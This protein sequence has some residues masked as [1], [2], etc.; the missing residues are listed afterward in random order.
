MG[1]EKRPYGSWPSPITTDLITADV[2]TL[3]EVRVDGDDLYWI[4]MRPAEK[5]RTVIVR[6]SAEGEI[7]DVTPA[8]FNA[9]TRV[10][11]YGGAPYLVHDGTVVFSNFAD[12]RLYRIRP[13]GEPEPLT[14]EAKLRFA[15]GIVDAARERYIFVCEDHGKEGVEPQNMIVTVSFESG[16]IRVLAEGRDFYAA[17]R[18]SP[19][20]SQLAVI[21]WDHP[22]MPWDE[23]DLWLGDFSDEGHLF[24][25]HRVA[26]GP[27][28]SVAEPRWSP[29]GILYLSLIHI[30]EP[31]RRH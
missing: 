12:Q 4:E 14:P 30:S 6:R 23:T 10:H 3:G 20:G 17:P 19:D 7:E 25:G 21:A 9:R 2:V 13:G 15:D 8:P 27:G 18:L 11:E 1:K 31:T 29:D 22:N 5:G 28:V 26:G 16:E 24:R